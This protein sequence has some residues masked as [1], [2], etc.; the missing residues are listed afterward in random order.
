MPLIAEEIGLRYGNPSTDPDDAEW[1]RCLAVLYG[2]MK[3]QS[4]GY[5]LPQE[6]ILLGNKYKPK[7]KRKRTAELD[8]IAIHSLGLYR[9]LG[10]GRSGVVCEGQ[11]LNDQPDA[12]KLFDTSSKVG[13]AALTAEMRAYECLESVQGTLVPQILGRVVGGNMQGFVMQLLAPLPP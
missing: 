6:P 4:C 12:V 8:T 13:V 11:R 10:R 9:V 7:G 2:S 1:C 5:F 3:D